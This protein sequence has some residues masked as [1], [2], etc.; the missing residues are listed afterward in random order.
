MKQ[1]Q[2]PIVLERLADIQQELDRAEA[3]RQAEPL[4]KKREPDLGQRPGQPT[5]AR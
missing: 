4:L 1:N 5:G 2:E 3:R